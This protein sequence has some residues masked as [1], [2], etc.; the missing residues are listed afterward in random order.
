M[1]CVNFPF[2]LAPAAPRVPAADKT[3]CFPLRFPLPPSFFFFLRLRGGEKENK[4]IHP[5]S[6]ARLETV[7][8]SR[9]EI[10]FTPW[11]TGP[12]AA[13]ELPLHEKPLAPFSQNPYH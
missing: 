2:S 5:F 7:Q 4:P 9:I 6:P 13:A 12:D 10:R 1:E 8:E 3:T 11:R